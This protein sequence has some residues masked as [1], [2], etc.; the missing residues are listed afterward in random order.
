MDRVDL[1]G[2]VAFAVWVVCR[3][4]DGFI[5]NSDHQLGIKMTEEICMQV[6]NDRGFKYAGLEDGDQCFCGVLESKP[7]YWIRNPE[8]EME[9]VIPPLVLQGLELVFLFGLVC[10]I[11]KDMHSRATL[12]N[13]L[14]YLTGYSVRKRKIAQR[15]LSRLPDEFEAFISVAP[16]SLQNEHLLAQIFEFLPRVVSARDIIPCLQTDPTLKLMKYNA[17]NPLRCAGCAVA[18]SPS[19]PHV[20]ITYSNM[21]EGAGQVRVYNVHSGNFVEARATGACSIGSLVV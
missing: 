20:L 15:C 17:V 14:E 8:N 19:H 16:D 6:C 13:L 1:A 21:A 5:Y 10:T 12:R 3:V 9:I 11:L 7:A 18:F 2:T 4:L